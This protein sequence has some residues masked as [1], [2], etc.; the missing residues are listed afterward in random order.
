[1]YLVAAVGCGRYGFGPL[2]E[3]SPDDGAAGDGAGEDATGD[4]AMPSVIRYPMDND[5]TSGTIPATVTAHNA[6]CTLCP[7]AT[8]GHRGGAYAFDGNQRFNLP[9]IT[10]VGL[11]PYTVAVWVLA[12]T[13]NTNMTAVSK[14]YDMTSNRDVFNL[15]VRRTDSRVVF[16]TTNQAGNS[17]YLQTPGT[18][19]LDAWRHLAATW[20][21]TTKRLYVDGVLSDVQV[22]SGTDS[23]F[24]IEVGADRDVGAVASFYRGALDE[25]RVLRPRARCQRD[26]RARRRI[27]IRVGRHGPETAENK[28]AARRPR[29]L[30]RHSSRC[31]V[32]SRASS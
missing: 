21:G 6:T 5:P 18:V 31:G 28:N 3:A 14:V 19:V 13:T 8:A 15:I 26:C 10:L 4:S 23:T 12:A 11:Q 16:E 17:T 29:S 30:A 1:M 9:T 27:A 2:G 20:D 22:S 25:S 32:L 24:S 7:T